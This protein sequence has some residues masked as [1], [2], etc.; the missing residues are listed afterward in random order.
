M[1]RRDDKEG[2]WLSENSDRRRIKDAEN[3]RK[4]R[5]EINKALSHGQV[6]RRDLVKWGLF[7]SAGILAPIGGL[8]PFVKPMHAQTASFGFGSGGS[9]I[10]TGLPS[11]P[12]FGVLPFTQ[13]M[14]R[15]DVFQRKPVSSLTP[16]PQAQANQTQQ[17]LDPAL[18]GGQTGRWPRPLPSR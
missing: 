12:L 4:N 6:S 15:F 2:F 3:A 7:T 10:P 17:P 5:A 14:P 16:A 11:S 18:V 1:G 9:G 13:P 8:S